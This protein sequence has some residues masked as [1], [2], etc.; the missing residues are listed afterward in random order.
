MAKKKEQKATMREKI[1]KCTER[2]ADMVIERQWSVTGKK[3]AMVLTTRPLRAD[4]SYV[5]GLRRIA[6]GFVYEMVDIV[7]KED[8]V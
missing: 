2:S 1:L 3:S 7:R 6:N 5:H 4:E 8:T